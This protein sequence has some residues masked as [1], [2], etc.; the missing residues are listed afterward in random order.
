[1]PAAALSVSVPTAIQG[2][3]TD[4]LGPAGA[5]AAILAT[6]GLLLVLPL[7]LTQRREIIRLLQWQE[8]EPERGDT[9]APHGPATGTGEAA[10]RPPRIGP[11]TPAERVTADRPALSRITAEHRALESPSFWR[12]LIAGG[13]R[14]P[15]LLS[16][17]TLLIATLGVVIVA[18][19]IELGDDGDTSG[20]GG[21]GRPPTSVIV[22]NAS[23]ESGLAN[24]I[25]DQI[26]SKQFAVNKLGAAKE[27]SQQTIVYFGEG[28]RKAAQKISKQLHTAVVQPF[29][30]E[31]RSEA[32]G[33]DLVVIAGEDRARA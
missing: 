2:V 14:H 26:A 30:D 11:M 21:G 6:I 33:A 1:M 20:G 19:V 18:L 25:G 10:A 32:D 5:A 28:S 9:G 23:S 4:V 15:I 16:L 27:P 7:Y 31:V 3:G 12:R 13:P 29:N 8:R 22:L 17:A 24:E